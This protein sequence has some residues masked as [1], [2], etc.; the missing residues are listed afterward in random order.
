MKEPSIPGIKQLSTSYDN[1]HSPSGYMTPVEF[2]QKEIK[3]SPLT[4]D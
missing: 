3:Q 2:E 4:R 1:H